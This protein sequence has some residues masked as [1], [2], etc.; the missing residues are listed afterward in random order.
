M[1]TEKTVWQTKIEKEKLDIRVHFHKYLKS[2]SEKILNI[3]KANMLNCLR[4][5]KSI[6]KKSITYNTVIYF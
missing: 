6:N 2:L 5:F 4:S 1:S 3:K